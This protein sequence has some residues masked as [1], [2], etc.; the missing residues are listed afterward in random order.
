MR[1]IYS[2]FFLGLALTTILFACSKSSS[3][4]APTILET[5]LQI[6]VLDNLGNPVSGASVK[7]YSTQTDFNNGTNQTSVTQTTN[8][9]G[10]VTF[11]AL[12][13]TRYYWYAYLDCK[14][15]LFGSITTTNDLTANIT[16]N[17]TT[18]IAST[19]TLTLKNNSANPYSISM[20]GAIIN[21]SIAGNSSIDYK[22]PSGNHTIVVTQLSGYLLVPTIK[23]YTINPTCGQILIQAF[24]N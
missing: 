17:V 18:I 4:P 20:D 8:S 9:S 10:I 14:S 12:I 23:T 7:L 11:Q 22:I 1:K 5:A 6:K 3:T 2:V 15:N 19:S 24:P 16:N 21:S 13:P